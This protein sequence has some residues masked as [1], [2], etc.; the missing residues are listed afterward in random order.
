MNA[1]LSA[2]QALGLLAVLAGAALVL[3]LWGA[4]VADGA[5]VLVAATA[6]ERIVL[7][8]HSGLSDGRRGPNRS[9]GV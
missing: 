3:P 9:R 2:L 6:V 1:V 8:A 7:G 5:L 4:L